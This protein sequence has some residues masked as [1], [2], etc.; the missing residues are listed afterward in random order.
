MASLAASTITIVDFLCL[1]AS[2]QQRWSFMA[3]ESFENMAAAVTPWLRDQLGE[4]A[5]EIVGIRQAANGFSAQTLFAKVLASPQTTSPLEVVLRLEHPGREI[6]LG[7]DFQRQASTMLALTCRQVPAPLL[8]G[9][10]D[11]PARI[12]RRFIAMHRLPGRGFPQSPSYVVAGW[13]KELNADGRATLWINAL[14]QLAEINRLD[15]TSGFQFL[16]QPQ[17][18]A[19]GLDQYLGWLRAWH[20]D[21]LVGEAHSVIDAGMAYLHR[22]PPLQLPTAVIWGDS[23]PSNMLFADDLS[24]SGVLDFEAAA[25]GPGEVDLGW[26]LFMDQRRSQGHP[27]LTGKPERDACIAIYEQALGRPAVAVDYF[28][29]MAGVRMAL[30]IARTARRLAAAGLLDQHSD[31]ATHNPIVGLLAQLLGMTPSQ[32]GQGFRDFV[33]AVS[34][35]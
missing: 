16:D 3:N 25:L 7:T 35:R 22:E 9:I 10:E 20:A 17:Y 24:I 23:N 11:D 30:V 13:V 28:E 6:F 31:A 32:P 8:I 18:G 15:W 19:A 2:I 21:V 14:R 4:S 26:W 27:P 33:A 34:R 29:I 5:A 12:G 1:L